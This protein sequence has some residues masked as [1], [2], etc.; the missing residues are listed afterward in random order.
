MVVFGASELE[1]ML[2]LVKSV[3]ITWLL[4]E[5][6]FDFFKKIAFGQKEWSLRQ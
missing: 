4:S 2:T 5:K 6:G 3:K 1:E